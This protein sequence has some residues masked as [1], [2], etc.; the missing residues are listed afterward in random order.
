MLSTHIGRER[1]CQLVQLRHSIDIW[2]LGPSTCVF[3][4]VSQVIFVT[5]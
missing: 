4:T 2:L 5:I 3:G 1:D